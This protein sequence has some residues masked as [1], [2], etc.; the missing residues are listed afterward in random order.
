MLA[1]HAP[2]GEISNSFT[3]PQNVTMAQFDANSPLFQGDE[4]SELR[5]DD[6]MLSPGD[7]V[8]LGYGNFPKPLTALAL[9]NT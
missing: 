5:S 6:T 4:L 9:A 1:D 7:M 2:A 8:E 3:R